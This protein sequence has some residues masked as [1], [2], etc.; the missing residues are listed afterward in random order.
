M[1]ILIPLILIACTTSGTDYVSKKEFDEYKSSQE[2]KQKEILLDEIKDDIEKNTIKKMQSDLKK[3]KCLTIYWNTEQ[4]FPVGA[5]SSVNSV[6]WGNIKWPH[7]REHAKWY[8]SNCIPSISSD[9][10]RKI[11]V[12]IDSV[13]PLIFNT[14]FNRMISTYETNW[15][16]NYP[17]FWNDYN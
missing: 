16:S 7:I 5:L 15:N 11:N 12:E 9:E 3:I 14:Y 8:V 17:K 4:M 6:Y 13:T 10:I 2:K 1:I